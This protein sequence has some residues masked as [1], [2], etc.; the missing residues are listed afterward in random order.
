MRPQH[1]KCYNN[2][3]SL[4]LRSTFPINQTQ[5]VKD[6]EE[7]PPPSPIPLAAEPPKSHY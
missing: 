6:F 5:K 7:N 4:H 2:L 3:L 1:R